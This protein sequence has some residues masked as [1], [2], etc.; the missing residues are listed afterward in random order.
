M[1]IRWIRYVVSRLREIEQMHEDGTFAKLTKKEVLMATRE[2]DKLERS[3]GRYQGNGR[4][5]G[6]HVR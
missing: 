4:P 3:I 2:Q 6:R 1:F 5:A